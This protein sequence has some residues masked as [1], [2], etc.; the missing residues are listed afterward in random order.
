MRFTIQFENL[1]SAEDQDV[2]NNFAYLH[3][4]VKSGFI[5]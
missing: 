5:L 1:T 4:G 3:M 2:K